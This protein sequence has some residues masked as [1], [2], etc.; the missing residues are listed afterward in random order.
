MCEQIRRVHEASFGLYG[1]R[2]V[3][4]QLRREGGK[5]TDT[6]RAAHLKLDRHA[7]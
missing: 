5:S 3:W 1:S 4:H 6:T 7:A 2:K